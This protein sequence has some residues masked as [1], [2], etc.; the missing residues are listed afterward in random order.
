M[1]AL[2]A[3]QV[4]PEAEGCAYGG[5]GVDARPPVP[6]QGATPG[7]NPWGGHVTHQ[8]GTAIAT[9]YRGIEYR[10]RLEARWAAL[11]AEAIND[12]KWRGRPA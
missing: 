3:G 6:N 8:S 4:R 5:I 9:V 12:V 2:V 7:C 10:S 1:Q 11:W